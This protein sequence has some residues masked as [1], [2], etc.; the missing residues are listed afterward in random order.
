M[1]SIHFGPRSMNRKMGHEHSYSLVEWAEA[2]ARNTMNAQ[3]GPSSWTKIT[4]LIVRVF[5]VKI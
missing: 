2:T 1:S 3:F 4:L 5:P